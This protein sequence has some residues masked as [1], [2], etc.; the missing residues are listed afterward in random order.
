[1][2][3]REKL[4]KLIDC[5]NGL[6][7]TQDLE[8]AGIPRHY[9]TI[10]MRENKLERVSR[11]VYLAPD[12][13][14]DAM[15]SIQARNQRAIFSHETAL[16]LHDL[17]DRDPIAWSVTVPFGYNA[18]HLKAEGIKIHTVKKTLH[19]MGVSDLKTMFGRPIKAYDKERTLCDIVRNRNNMDPAILNEAIKR[20]L[21][22]KDKNIPLMMR[23]AKELDVQNILRNYV[24]IIL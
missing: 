23:Y 22:S 19:Q 10:L 15:Y 7:L 24:E 3:Y 13:F 18:S 8:S 9:L 12:A 5:N 17:S 11:G 6:I 16:F 1:M 20:Y 4:E 2:N 21:G 14:D